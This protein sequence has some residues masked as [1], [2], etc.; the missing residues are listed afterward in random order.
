MINNMILKDKISLCS[1]YESI[2]DGLQLPR[3]GHFS[4]MPLHMK[5][6]NLFT[7]LKS[8][9][10]YFFSLVNKKT[11]LLRPCPQIGRSVLVW[12]DL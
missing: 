7:R 2:C 10:I 9:N 3:V 5:E 6:Q 12:Y 1:H 4:D 8:S 11:N